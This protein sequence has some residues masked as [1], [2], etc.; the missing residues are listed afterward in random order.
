MV[1]RCFAALAGLVLAVTVAGPARGQD[2]VTPTSVLIGQSAAFTG[3]AAQ[4]GIQMRAGA[5]L[6]I[7]HVNAQGGINGRT[8]ELKSRDDKYES[9]AGGGKHQAADQR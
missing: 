7:D 4:L 5:K 3:P 2:G 8:I 6:W 9:R 1:L